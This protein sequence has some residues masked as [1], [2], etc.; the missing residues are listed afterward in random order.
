MSRIARSHSN[1]LAFRRLIWVCAAA[2]L[3]AD[4]SLSRAPASTLPQPPTARLNLSGEASYDSLPP[5][6]IRSYPVE[7]VRRSDSGMLYLFRDVDDVR[8]RVGQVILFKNE[9]NPVMGFRV[10]Q[11]YPEQRIFA[12]R[13]IRRYDE[14]QALNAGEKYTAIEKTGDRI[15]K[16]QSAQDKLDVAALEDEFDGLLEGSGPG[17]QDLFSLPAQGPQDLG[18]DLESDVWPDGEF[19]DFDEELP[20]PEENASDLDD[21]EGFDFE[22]LPDEEL[23]F[24]DEIANE[25]LPLP[26]EIEFAE[27]AEFD[28]L[29]LEELPDPDT[30]DLSAFEEGPLDFER[31]LAED[32]PDYGTGRRIAMTVEE[33]QPLEKYNHMM[34]AQV[35]YIRNVKLDG[36]GMY[37]SALGVRYSYTFARMGW[38]DSASVQDSWALDAGLYHYRLFNYDSD[39][40]NSDA[41][42][43]MPATATFRYNVHLSSRTTFF[44]QGGILKNTVLSNTVGSETNALQ[45]SSFVPAGGAG[46]L[47]AIGPHWKTRV[48]VGYDAT[49]I[50]LVLQF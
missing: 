7:V 46:L 16:E 32:S 12:A 26:E 36:T 8:T 19:E 20:L 48:D 3:F 42:S 13:R 9:Q 30:L 15:P 41:Y 37:A 31:S 40:N 34:A 17:G 28:D 39:P 38:L 1:R 23:P 11:T 50:G 43:V 2:L 18:A 44:L 4:G 25:E 24:P 6:H 45:L 27:S 10:L 5:I 22:A 29:S 49:A 33:I 35:S 47:F 21:L 14:Y